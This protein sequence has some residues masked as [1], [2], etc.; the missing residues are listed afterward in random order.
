MALRDQPYFPLYIQDYMTDEKL[1]MCSWATQ[2]IYIKILCVLHKQDLYGKILF[3]QNSKQTD[4][5]NE[6]MIDF[7]AS[8]LV[9]QIP[10][11]FDEMKLAL[12]ELIE[13]D[14]MSINDEYLYQK[15]MVRDG[16]ISDTRSKAAK[17]GGGNPILFKQNSKQTDKQNP[18]YE[19][20]YEY[21]D[22]NEDKEGIKEEGMGEEKKGD[23]SSDPFDHDDVYPFDDF[24]DDYAKKV[25]EKSKLRKKWA[26][27]PKS[28]KLIIK[29]YIPMY[30]EAQ[31]DKQFRK[32]PETFLNNKSW[33]DEIIKR[34]A[35][36]TT[37]TAEQK[38]SDIEDYK[39]SIF[40]RLQSD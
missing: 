30:I 28:E 16:E 10:C 14:V 13:N 6:S 9:R 26:K 17:K 37:T 12:M 1:N 18:E 5:Q 8:V 32:N 7:F 15:R 3:K 21:E 31:P 19:Y 24:W 22:K 38:R 27:I 20:E 25:G 40:K 34:D 35:I 4:K 2:G 36:K 39:R 23:K 29:R 33:Q 11:Q